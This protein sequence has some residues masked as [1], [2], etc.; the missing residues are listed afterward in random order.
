MRISI[1][2]MSL[3][4]LKRKVAEQLNLQAPQNAQGARR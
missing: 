1:W 4:E 3:D 2:H